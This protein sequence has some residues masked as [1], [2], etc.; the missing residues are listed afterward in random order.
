MSSWYRYVTER[1]SG[2]FAMR[3]EGLS[4]EAMLADLSDAPASNFRGLCFLHCEKRGLY[5]F[6]VKTI[7]DANCGHICAK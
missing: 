6:I 5:Q 1:L 3:Y 2:R 7:N 4:S